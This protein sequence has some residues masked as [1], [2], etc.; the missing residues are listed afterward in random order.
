MYQFEFVRQHI[1]SLKT[2]KMFVMKIENDLKKMI[3]FLL[4]ENQSDTIL[5]LIS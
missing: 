3:N 4:N 2:I 5:C 1:K